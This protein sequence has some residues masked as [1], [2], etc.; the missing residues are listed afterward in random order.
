MPA[1]MVSKAAVVGDKLCRTDYADGECR[2]ARTNNHK[3]IETKVLVLFTIGV[4][5][6]C[7]VIAILLTPSLQ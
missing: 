1:V 7:S 5:L 3:L 2:K 4:P 6:V